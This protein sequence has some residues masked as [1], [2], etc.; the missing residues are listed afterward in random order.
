MAAVHGL[1]AGFGF[2]AYATIITF[3]L[4]P[5]VPGLIY[6][7]LVGVCFGLGTMVMQVIFGAV[8]ARFARLRK[9]SEDDVCYLGRA[10][11][12]RTLYYGG[13]LFALVGLFILLFPAVEGLAVSTGN[14]IPNLDSIGIATVLVLAVVGG[15]GIWAMIKGLRELRAI[16]S[17]AYCHPAPT[18]ARSPS[19]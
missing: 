9:L 6:A 8:F 17:G 16:D 12:G 5:E 4:A 15:V 13:M 19:R 3:V 1:I 7:P 14:P 10:T 2:G 11:G 18:D